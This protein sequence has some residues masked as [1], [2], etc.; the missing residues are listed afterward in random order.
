M[1][2]YPLVQ[3]S[4]INLYTN[5]KRAQVED[6]STKHQEDSLTYEFKH[7]YIFILVVPDT[8][9]EDGTFCR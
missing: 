4:P 3:A 8:E 2:M 6:R 7:S 1:F 9:Y 5:K